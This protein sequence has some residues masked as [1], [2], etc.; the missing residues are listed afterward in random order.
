MALNLTVL[1]FFNLRRN[2]LKLEVVA[3][4]AGMAANLIRVP[5]IYRPGLVLAG[6]FRFFPPERIQ[7]LGRTEITYLEDLDAGRREEILRKMFAEPVVCLVVTRPVKTGH[8]LRRWAQ[9]K[10]IPLLYSGLPTTRLVVE[11]T[12]FLENYLAPSVKMHATL[13]EVYGLGVLLLGRSGIGKSECALELVKRGHRMITDD[14]VEIR[15]TKDNFLAGSGDELI[16]QHM[17]LR[18]LGIIDVQELFGVGAVR[19]DCEIQL[20]INIETWQEGKAY[21]RT[22]LDM[23]TYEILGVSL[24]FVELPVQPGRSLAIIIEVAAMNE[25]LRLSG[26]NPAERFN[27]RITRAL[28]R[29]QEARQEKIAAQPES[30]AAKAPAKKSVKKKKGKGRR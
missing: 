3:G 23:K 13:V 26:V 9:K 1:E 16:Q 18:G 11:M 20:V 29:R 15:R 12:S 28:A 6:Y 14:L 22:G 8:P 2:A 10:N 17:E 4:Q 27:Q 21:E 19:S 25:R 24:P 5:D 30:A 7:V